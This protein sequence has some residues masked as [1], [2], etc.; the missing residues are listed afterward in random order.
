MKPNEPS[1]P[2]EKDKPIQSTP[3]YDYLAFF[4]FLFVLF[5]SAFLYLEYD[6]RNHQE[7]HIENYNELVEKYNNL[8]ARYNTL[9][10][11]YTVLNALIG[12]SSEYDHCTP[13]DTTNPTNTTPPQPKHKLGDYRNCR[14]VKESERHINP[15]HPKVKELSVTLGQPTNYNHPSTEGLIHLIKS[16]KQ[17][18]NNHITYVRQNGVKTIDNYI[19]SGE[20][21]CTERTLLFTSILTNLGYN[22]YFTVEKTDTGYHAYTII[23]HNT[24]IIEV[25]RIGGTLLQYYNTT[26]AIYCS[27]HTKLM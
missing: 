26:H 16:Y 19:L 5:I 11:K 22:A 14:V 2:K 3:Q 20:G 21:D 24:N 18:Q 6:Y 1:P 25:D 13:T 10:Y 27:S 7:Q 12:N 9:N 17:W 8:T 23:K 4:I 15:T